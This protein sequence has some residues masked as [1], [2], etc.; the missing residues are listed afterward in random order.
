MSDAIALKNDHLPGKIY[1]YRCVNDRSLQNLQEDTIWLASPDKYNDP[2]DCLFSISD[3]DILPILRHTLNAELIRIYGPSA[4]E[5]EP[6]HADRLLREALEGIRKMRGA[7]KICSF[8]AA[9]NIILMWS[10]LIESAHDLHELAS[11]QEE[12]A[13]QYEGDAIE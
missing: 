9:N 8:N 1:K 13:P 3:E 5:L 11:Q 12:R 4:P 6:A 2:F 7:T 10:P